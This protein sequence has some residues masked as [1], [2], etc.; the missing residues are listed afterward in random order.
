MLGAQIHWDMLRFGL[1]SPPP[2]VHLGACLGE[3]YNLA[4]HGDVEVQEV[5]PL[6]AQAGTGMSLPPPSV[7]KSNHMVKPRVKGERK[8]V[9][10]FSER[11]CHHVAGA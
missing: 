7:G 3:Q 8:H 10:C 5:R 4:S 11:H 1:R 6:K 2:A 9:L